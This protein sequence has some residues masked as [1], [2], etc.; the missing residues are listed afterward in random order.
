MLNSTFDIFMNG[1]ILR[2]ANTVSEEKGLPK[3]SILAGIEEALGLAAKKQLDL[4]EIP[5][6]KIDRD[7]GSIH[8]SLR[9]KPLNINPSLLGRIAAQTMKQVIRQKIHEAEVDLLYKEVL[10][11]K[12]KIVSCVIEEIRGS[13]VICRIG[14]LEA[15]LSKNDQV[16][17]ETYKKGLTIRALLYSVKKNGSN[18][19]IFLSRSS[20]LFVK[21]LF[22]LEIPEISDGIVLIKAIVRDGGYR[23]KIAVH[24]NDQKIDPVSSCVGVKGARIRNIVNELNGENIDVV[25][26]S[27]LP[28][29][30]VIEAL[31]PSAIS[32]CLIDEKTHVATA[33]VEE[34]FLAQAIGKQGKNVKLASRLTGWDIQVVLYV[35]PPKNP[36]IVMNGEIK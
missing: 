21:K 32:K 4:Q 11:K 18:I 14:K 2:F 6:I 23:T 10:D 3:E 27:D 7:T 24:S 28:T 36:K 20:T 13:N 1:E 5:Y 16:F 29:T 12:D 17:G 33:F 35:P 15:I 30:F 8:S 9:G 34:E 26:W 31:K 22:E 19:K 25:R